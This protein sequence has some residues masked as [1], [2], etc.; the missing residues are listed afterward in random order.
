[1]EACSD[2]RVAVARQ[3][4]QDLQVVLDDGRWGG[5]GLAC[6]A[7]KRWLHGW[8]GYGFSDAVPTGFSALS[9][10][11]GAN[12]D[13]PADAQVCFSS[14]KKYS[15]LERRGLERQLDAD[16]GF[17]YRPRQALGDGRTQAADALAQLLGRH[18]REVQPHGVRPRVVRVK[19]LAGHERDPVLDS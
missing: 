7:S 11:V 19:A 4:V 12:C 17:R 3:I 18:V 8:G 14:E 15:H 5:G 10:T 16:W 6:V 2:D 9:F 1:G 13:F